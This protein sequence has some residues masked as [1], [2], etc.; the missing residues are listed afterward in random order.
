M[1]MD[2]LL[3]V[4]AL[5]TVRT[6]NA[7]LLVALPCCHTDYHMAQ[8]DVKAD[9]LLQHHRLRSEASWLSNLE[10]ALFLTW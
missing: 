8:V 7:A 1:F 3:D 6:G 5:A 9:L 2:M 10:P 4:F